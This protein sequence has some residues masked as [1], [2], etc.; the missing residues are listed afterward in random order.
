MDVNSVYE[1]AYE[2]ARQAI[3][4]ELGGEDVAL[5]RRMI[6]GRVLFEDDQGRE[7]RAVGAEALF[8]KVTS[9][10]EKLRVLEQKLN[11]HDKLDAAEK[12]ELQGYITRCYG[13]LTTFN[14]LFAEEDDKFRGTGS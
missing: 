14:F 2:A 12:A 1:A 3:R 9:V 7:A 4:D 5:S 11:N 10:R 13:S 6:G 8:K